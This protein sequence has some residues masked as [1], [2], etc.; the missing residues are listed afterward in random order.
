MRKNYEPSIGLFGNTNSMGYKI[1]DVRF[2]PV[3]F[4]VSCYPLIGL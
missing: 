2:S 1:S 4:N 3:E